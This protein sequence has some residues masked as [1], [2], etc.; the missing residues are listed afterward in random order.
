M[1][2]SGGEEFPVCFEDASFSTAGPS[3]G[4]AVAAGEA[5]TRL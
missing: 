2:G 5:S 1:K 4:E 3:D